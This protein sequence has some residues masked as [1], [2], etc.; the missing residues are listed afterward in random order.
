MSDTVIGGVCG[1][2]VLLFTSLVAEN[3]R[4]QYLFVSVPFTH[5]HRPLR[6]MFPGQ[7]SEHHCLH[8]AKC[9][10]IFTNQ[11][12]VRTRSDSGCRFA[13]FS[14]LFFHDQQH[15]PVWQHCANIIVTVEHILNSDENELVCQADVLSFEN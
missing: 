12:F 13:D 2:L 14:K 3:R 10:G 9:L 7:L 6:R 5:L 4:A 1:T 15:A 8:H 11:G